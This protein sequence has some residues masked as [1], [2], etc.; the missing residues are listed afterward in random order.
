MSLGITH[1]FDGTMLHS[2]FPI[3]FGSSNGEIQIN[4]LVAFQELARMG[5]NG[6]HERPHVFRVHVRVQPMTQISDVALHAKSLQHLLHDLRYTL[7]TTSK[8]KLGL[9]IILA[10]FV[11]FFSGLLIKIYERLS[12]RLDSH[13]QITSEMMMEKIYFGCSKT[14]L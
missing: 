10:Q 8:K 2:L 14:M 4:I 9:F 11:L 12:K 1:Y 3:C 6:L 7:L 5:V 13:T